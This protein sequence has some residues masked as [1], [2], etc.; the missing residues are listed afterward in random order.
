MKHINGKVV[1]VTGASAGIGAAMVRALAEAGAHIVLVA[2]RAE[3]LTQLIDSLGDPGGRCVP[4]V[5]DLQDVAFCQQLI[6][7]TVSE[8][9]R[10]DVLINN[11][12]LGH[13]SAISKIPAD[14]M[15]TIVDTNIL[16]PLHTCQAAIPYMREQGSGQ[17]I[18]VSSIVGQRPLPHSGFYCASKTALNFITRSLR[19]ELR[20]DNITVTLL[21]PGMTDTNFHEATLGAGRRRRGWSGVSAERVA[22][23]T[24]RAIHKQK[25][26]VYV[27]RIDWLFTHLNRIFP[28]TLDYC[29]TVIWRG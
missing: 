20:R 6:D 14:H 29:A 28:R 4:I 15:H 27:T 10:I 13:R 9:G 25:H 7:D 16:A 23:A 17:I 26:E 1:V 12:G 22:S 11:A 21:Y 19:M 24:L 18:N 5:G 8:F 3:R 2:R